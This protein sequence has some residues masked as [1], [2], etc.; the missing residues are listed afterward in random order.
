MTI[1]IS[2]DCPL[3]QV[4]MVHSSLLAMKLLA[5]SP[6][7]AMTWV[8]K[9]IFPNPDIVRRAYLSELK[10][11]TPFWVVGAFDVKTDSPTG[12]GIRLF[13]MYTLVRMCV[14]LGYV[15]K[16]AASVFT[17]F[18]LVI[19]Y[20]ITCYMTLSVIYYYREAL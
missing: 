1:N 3:T 9:G 7:T 16:P 11:L 10:N 5:L 4:Y 12:L 8:R 6:M 14:I 20:F 13:R 15:T 18:A 19:S 17:D 2:L